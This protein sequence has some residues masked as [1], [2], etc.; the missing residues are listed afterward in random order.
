MDIIRKNDKEYLNLDNAEFN[1]VKLCAVMCDKNVYGETEYL[2]C[3]KEFDSYFNYLRKNPP[4]LGEVMK[5]LL[6]SCKD[7]KWPFTH[8][9]RAEFIVYARKTY[10]NVD[11]DGKILATNEYHDHMV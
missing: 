7:D 11:I 4:S 10:W 5:N 2:I 8:A 9:K 1:K 6:N 3:A